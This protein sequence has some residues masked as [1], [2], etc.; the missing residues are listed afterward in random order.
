MDAVNPFC[1][2]LLAVALAA[3]IG[4][5]TDGT[6]VSKARGQM[7]PDPRSPIAPIAPIAPVVASTPVTGS[8]VAG[9]PVG[10]D[11]QKAGY[12][13]ALTE[14]KGLELLKSGVP[15]IKVV[16]L[17]GATNLVTDQEVVEAVRQHLSELNVIDPSMRAQKEKEM[18]AAELRRIIARELILDE[19]YTKLK[20]SGKA[21]AIDDIKDYAG[22]AAD[23]TVRGIRKNFPSD[24]IFQE[25]MNS[26]GQ[27]I[28][29]LRRQFERQTMA[30]EYVRSVLKDKAR[31]PGF[32][33]MRDY[34]DKHPDEFKNTDKVLWLDIFISYGRHPTPQAAYAHAQSIF[35]TAALGADF[36]AL[37]K[38]H[39]N[40]VSGQQ[41][42]IGIGHVRGEIKPEDVEATVWSLQPGDVSDP[43]PTPA[44]YH[45]VKVVKREF[46]GQRAFDAKVQNE[47]REKL[48]RKYRDT[49]E[50]K[51]IEELWRRGPVRLIEN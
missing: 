27:S 11:V 31:S 7:P 5:T 50:Q 35:Q 6:S 34:Y 9:T 45:I 19:M 26:Q 39:D 32:A 29:V 33:D 18:Y 40:G 44:G 37:S 10:P 42:G 36:P 49:E 43:I 12:S 16:A 8:P 25:Y 17:V 1:R 4:C 15:Q 51:M 24:E 48:L 14:T 28:P 23:F 2:C 30:N 41:G 20:K 47:V 21:A 13:T 22:K 3:I 38:K 46:A